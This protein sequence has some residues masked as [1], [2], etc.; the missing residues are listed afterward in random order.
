[1][2]NQSNLTNNLNTHL[3]SFDN[4]LIFSYGVMVSTEDSNSF[5]QGSNPCERRIAIVETSTWCY[6]G[7]ANSTLK[8]DLIIKDMYYDYCNLQTK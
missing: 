6:S 7:N 5:R 3:A 2:S 8:N 4:Q 1:M